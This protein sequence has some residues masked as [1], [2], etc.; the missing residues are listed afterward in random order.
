MSNS[1]TIHSS[2]L[3]HPYARFEASTIARDYKKPESSSVFTEAYFRQNVSK[4]R[5]S[6]I[7]DGFTNFSSETVSQL[8]DRLSL[9][10]E[11]SDPKSA[12]SIY[13][14]AIFSYV[15]EVIHTQR[16]PFVPIQLKNGGVSIKTRPRSPISVENLVR[17]V[18]FP[19]A[20]NYLDELEDDLLEALKPTSAISNKI[21]EEIADEI[22]GRNGPQLELHYSN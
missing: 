17:R 13:N 14:K 4:I 10:E 6:Y 1:P 5:D 7:H 20:D 11:G 18:P 12:Q 9:L 15:Y 16:D 2:N 8:R 19:I 3:S 22:L 21:I